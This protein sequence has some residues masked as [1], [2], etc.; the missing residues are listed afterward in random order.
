MQI[1]HGTRALIN[2]PL[3]TEFFPQNKSLTEFH[4]YKFDLEL[5][6]KELKIS[7]LPREAR[8]VFTLIGRNDSFE[9][10]PLAWAALQL[11]DAEL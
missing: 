9:Q 3:V 10:T 8:L 6:Y 11:F 5:E 4:Y 2:M 7:N 1:F